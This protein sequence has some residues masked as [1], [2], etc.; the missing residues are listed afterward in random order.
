MKRYVRIDYTVKPNVDL[1][2]LRGEI[3]KFVAGFR[4][5][6]QE[7]R[8]TSLQY[9]NDPRRFTH[10]AELNDEVN[11]A[12]PKQPFFQRF[13][14]YLGEKCSSG[15]EVIRLNCLASTAPEASIYEEKPK[16]FCKRSSLALSR[17]SRC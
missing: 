16:L 3:A 14:G 17:H 6:H 2:E 10:F 12:I 13:T 9:A 7:H 11:D 8:Y 5:H 4:A 1:E 15:P